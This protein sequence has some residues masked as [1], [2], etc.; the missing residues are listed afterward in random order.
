MSGQNSITIT[1]D[2]TGALQGIQ[3]TTEA[4]ERLNNTAREA[5]AQLQATAEVENPFKVVLEGMSEATS[6]A[7]NY[8]TVVGALKNLPADLAGMATPF[9]GQKVALEAATVATRGLSLA[10]TALPLVA[11]AAAVA[12]LGTG[13][14][15]MLTNTQES[16][17]QYK[18][19]NDAMTALRPVIGGNGESLDRFVLRMDKATASTRQLTLAAL[20]AAKTTAETERKQQQA[21]ASSALGRMEALARAQVPTDPMGNNFVTEPDLGLDPEVVKTLQDF[22]KSANKDVADLAGQLYALGP[23]GKEALQTLVEFQGKQVSLLELAV[24]SQGTNEALTDLGQKMRVARGE[25]TAAEQATLEHTRATNAATGAV[26]TQTACLNELAVAQKGVADGMDMSAGLA[27]M[28]A[29]FNASVAATQQATDAMVEGTYAKIQA[30]FNATLAANAATPSQ[31]VAEGR[32]ANDAAAET[33]KKQAEEVNKTAETIAKGW[34]EALFNQITGKGD[35]IKSWFKGLFKQIASDALKNKIIVPVTSAIAGALGGFGIGALTGTADAAGG[36]GGGG[37]ATGGNLLESLS[38][39][40][41]KALDGLQAGVTK[42]GSSLFGTAEGFLEVPGGVSAK[43]AGSNGLLGSGGQFLGS[44]NLATGI[45]GALSGVGLGMTAGGLLGALGI[46]KGN[47]TGAAIGGAIGG[48]V[49]SF[50]PVLGTALGGIL[51]GALGSLFGSKPSNKEGNAVIDLSAG[52]YTIGGFT[53]KKY[54]QENRDAAGDL[55]KQVLSIKDALEKGFGAKVTGTLAVGAG[56]RDGLFATSLNS[57][58]RTSF[59]KDEAGAKQ[60]VAFV[61]G[62]FVTGIKDQLAPEIGA[63][64]GRV[65][66]GDMTKA[67]GDL[68]FIRNFRDSLGALKEDMGL[69]NQA[70]RAAAD[71]VRTQTDAIKEFR[72]TTARLFPDAVA[73]ADAA[74]KSYVEGLVGIRQ[75]ADP[76]T[77]METAMIALQARFEAY[78]PLLEEVGYTAEQ[79]QEAI[80]SG[81]KQAKD[82]LKGDYEKTLDRQYNELTGKGYVNQINDLITNRDTGL[83]DAAAL[84]VDPGLVTRNFTAGL[85]AQLK[86]LDKSQLE[87]LLVT[88]AGVTDVAT[89]V[90]TALARLNG[91]LQQTSETAEQIAARAARTAE[92]RDGLL[93]R[94][95]RATGAADTEAGQLDIFDRAAKTEKEATQKRINEGELGAEAL[96]E[97]EATLAAER[98]AITRDFAARA[99]EAA[100]ANAEKQAEIARSL[101][102]RVAALQAVGDKDGDIRLLER[103]QKAEYDAAVAAGWTADQLS[104]LSDVL[105]GEMGNAVAEKQRQA[106]AA[107][108]AVTSSLADRVATLYNATLPDGEIRNLERKQ[109]AEYDAAVAAGWTAGQLAVLSD[110]LKVE[111]A[112]AIDAAAARIRTLNEGIQD[113]LFAAT[114]DTSTLSGALAA[115]DRKT[116]KERAD[117]ARNAGADLVS[118]DQATAA[119]RLKIEKDF[120]DRAAAV[121]QGFADRLFAAT[122]D[123]D[124]LSGALAAFDRQA[125][126]ERLDAAKTGGAN[127]ALLEKAQGAERAR[128]VK[129]FADKAIAEAQA[130]ADAARDKLIQAYQREA[131]AARTLAADW[132]DAGK[133]I[134]DALKA[135]KLSD[136]YSNLN[137][138]QRAALAEQELRRLAARAN[139]SSLTAQERLDAA[140]ALPE[141]RRTF[142]DAVRPLYEGTERWGEALDMSAKLLE[143]V[144]DTG[145]RQAD[146]AQRQVD[147]AE[148]QLTALGVVNDSVLSVADALDRYR[149]AVEKLAEVKAAAVPVAQSPA[150][151]AGIPANDQPTTPTIEQVRA[152]LLAAVT[153]RSMLGDVEVLTWQKDGKTMGALSKEEVTT[154]RPLDYL[155]FTARK[156]GLAGYQGGGI[157]G[158]GLYNT[159]SVLARYQD[160][161]FVALAGGEFVTRAPSVNNDT[162]PLLRAINDTGRPPAGLRSDE[163]SARMERLLAALLS[164]AEDNGRRQAELDAR[165]YD[166]LADRLTGLLAQGQD[167]AADRRRVAR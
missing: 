20:D 47:Q 72:E 66:F 138:D 38:G 19:L 153:M 109:K 76:L 11:I 95:A 128:I 65:D 32:K 4:L 125:A 152:D 141:A 106:A 70:A 161:G 165:G 100:K 29:Q 41:T 85:E 26:Q 137:P 94:R 82:Q 69:Q 151:A 154:T 148:G 86:N 59:S 18:N 17:R 99:L 167:A 92:F 87:G 81:L 126:K 112:Q 135:D 56:D 134:R 73:E 3:G 83:K 12:A 35:G 84:G 127:L 57:T 58:A 140:Q 61:T 9:L 90:N 123:A 102:D 75:A 118:F 67:A 96:T 156:V 111:M 79:A 120:A 6:L 78:K 110:V 149:Q 145:D 10:M 55:A 158:N 104:I 48:V 164:Q 89:V 13:L 77:Q 150:P 159:D 80:A 50:V 162:L 52:S 60:L 68:D 163:G 121:N 98:E 97:L 117:I 136:Q 1:V 21:A 132:R 33:G 107:E 7:S 42:L 101:G 5:L 155:L 143:G 142:L 45:T 27:E 88:F 23:A 36:S 146:L 43:I 93:D 157:I 133:S 44:T 130:N 40:L 124:T 129:S 14:Y 51:G 31:I 160:G 28:T 131:D 24:A 37:G 114:T 39:G 105:K 119:E 116:A 46:G 122:N 91:T 147:L 30:D 103:K 64:L 34:G 54:S 144:A 8:V 16:T 49:G 115:F 25:L 139:D 166:L 22:A 2:A 108:A 15:Q 53:G 71:A 62:E 113:R 63:A 74:L